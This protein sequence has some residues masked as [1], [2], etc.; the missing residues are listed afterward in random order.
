MNNTLPTLL[1]AEDDDN[2]F[3]FFERALIAEKL[4]AQIRRACDGQEAIEYVRGDN[5]F[6]DRDEHPL[7]DMIVLDLKMP[8]KSGF[9]VLAW[10]RKHPDFCD[11]PVI[12]FSSSEEH[13]DVERA[14]N[15]GASAYLVKPSSYTSYS[16]VVET[17]KQF[18]SDGCNQAAAD[19]SVR[20]Y[21]KSA[22][23]KCV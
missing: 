15:L 12:V 3:L 13:T 17:L 16:E 8:R 2:D 21:H 6:A 23:W 20:T 18:L 10:L 9:E 14:Y 4:E 5:H 1:I 19:R 7:P 11:L 22:N